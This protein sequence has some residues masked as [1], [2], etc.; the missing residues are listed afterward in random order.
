MNITSLSHQ[1]LSLVAP[2]A[3]TNF[4]IRMA[5]LTNEAVIIPDTSVYDDAVDFVAMKNAGAEGVF[6]RAGQGLVVDN[7]LKRSQ[8]EA[9]KAGLIDGYYWFL[10]PRVDPKRQAET[11]WATVQNHPGILPLVIDYE[12]PDSWGGN[13]SGWKN[14]YNF[15]ERLKQILPSTHEIMIYTGYYYWLEHSPNPI[16]QQASLNYFA[17]YPLWLAWYTT[18]IS[19]VKI[20]KPWADLLFLQ[21]T[22]SGKWPLGQDLSYYNGSLAEFKAKYNSSNPPTPIPTPL[23]SPNPVPPSGGSMIGIATVTYSNP[24]H[25]R[26]SADIYGNDLGHDLLPGQTFNVVNRTQPSSTKAPNSVNDI[27]LQLPD[28]SWTAEIYAGKTYCSYSAYV[29]VTTT[30]TPTKS[31]QID[32][33]SDGSL[34]IDGKV[35]A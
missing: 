32:V 31:H 10:D 27:W 18:D 33:M 1:L 16:T 3:K 34:V 7:Q 24:V 12:A 13:Y 23:P 17:Q 4:N 35:Y 29:P 5:A 26:D 14:L 15:L 28:G 9:P 19:T 20:P 11:L 8:I 30:S 25:V 22:E 2:D 21:Y 6:I